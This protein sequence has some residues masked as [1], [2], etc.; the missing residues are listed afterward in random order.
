MPK[1]IAFLIILT[2]GTFSINSFAFE[3]DPDGFRGIKWGTKL[4]T[5]K[6]MT[7]VR[8]QSDKNS[9]F[10][11]KNNENLQIGNA[12]LTEI[13][14]VF[15]RDKF[16]AVIVKTEGYSNWSHLKDAAFAKFGKGNQKNKQIE[17]YK[18]GSFP[19]GKT[20]IVLHYNQLPKV[21]TFVM[22]GVKVMKEQKQ[23]D[24]QKAKEGATDF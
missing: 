24:K 15:W 10:C 19:N 23:F 11:F 3:N 5:L 14:Y 17:G 1:L 9:T 2:I 8:K 6:G 18:W 16:Y 12:Q 13:G 22:F 7:K 4:E 20:I 21:G